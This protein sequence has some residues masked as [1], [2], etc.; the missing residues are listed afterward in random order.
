MPFA[1]SSELPPPSATMESA[2]HAR[3]TSAPRIT[4][5]PSGSWSNSNVATSMPAWV[6]SVRARSGWP[7]FSVM[8]PTPL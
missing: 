3:A 6:S 2:P 4:I 1:Q 8:A 7:L 5:A